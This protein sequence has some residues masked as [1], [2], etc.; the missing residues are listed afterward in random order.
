M[1]G[2]TYHA[3]PG[4]RG[5]GCLPHDTLY[6]STAPMYDPVCISLSSS[7]CNIVIINN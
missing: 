4:G 2:C 5:G 3:L 7:E 1:A 6:T